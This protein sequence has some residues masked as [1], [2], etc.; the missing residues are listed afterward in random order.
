MTGN[1]IN[2]YAHD[3]LAGHVPAGK[4]HRLACVR[5]DYD[6]LRANT[7]RFP[8]RLDLDRA[9]RFFRFAAKLKHYKGEWA[10]QPIILQPYQQFR[11]GSIFGWVHVET[12][13]RRFRTAY[14]EIPRKSGKSLEAAVVALYATFFDGE[15][16]AEGYTIATKRDQARIVFA[17]AQ[18]LVSS[19]GLKT[20]IVVQVARLH[21]HATASKLEPLGADHDSTDGLNPHCIIVDEFH[22]HKTRGLIDVMETA[23]GARRQPLTFQ[24]TTAG[25]D[26][27]SPGGDQHDYA[28]KILDGVLVDESFFAFIAHADI[29]DDWRAESTWRKANP[30]YG[31][32]VNPDDMRALAL[33]A[34][35]MPAAAATFQQKR[36]NIWVNTAQ[37]W[38]SVDGWR[39]GQHTDWTADDLAGE[40]CYVGV[41]LASKLDLCAMMFVFP[42]TPERQGWRLLPWV[43][44]PEDTLRERAHR[45]RAPYDIWVQQ[46]H[47]LT[48][49]GTSI[50]HSL[51]RQ[52]L[53]AQ[54]ERFKIARIGFDPWHSDMLIHQLV[55]EDGF[56]ADQVV[57]VP[58][59]F[60]HMSSAALT[61]EASVLNGHVDGRESPLLAWCVSN[62]VVQRDGKDNIQPIKKKSRGRI[63]PVVA[64]IIG[65]SLAARAPAQPDNVYLSRGVRRLGETLHA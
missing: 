43:W 23:T 60:A 18:K 56:A 9:E 59:T 61:F 29:G 62:A 21:E 2:G 12:G 17:D 39:R 22:A 26:P 63:D 50:D 19:S 37:P 40:T 20:R 3:V 30:N 25:D 49:P 11:L 51:L 15:P 54:R 42:P 14:N 55:S 52:V 13:R 31:V 34:T 45:D 38:L 7:K 44:T 65:V 1:P 5:H 41:D 33:K 24:I 53:V 58:Q 57:E 36:L 8:Y 10:G 6:V 35:S 48:S 4:Y 32:S 47:L 16:G 64:S 27:V 28:C 46:G